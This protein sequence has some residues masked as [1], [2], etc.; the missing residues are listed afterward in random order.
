M[1]GGSMKDFRDYLKTLK[2]KN[3]VVEIEDA[4]DP[5]IEIGK[6]QKSYDGKKTIFFKQIKG[7]DIPIVSNIFNKRENI[8][9]AI[10]VELADLKDKIIGAVENPINTV[11]I[12]DAPI[13]EVVIKDDINPLKLLPI[14]KHYQKDN[15]RYITSGVILA[16]DPATGV[17][18]LSFARMKVNAGNRINIMINKERH[19]MRYLLKAEKMSRPLEI[20]IIIGAHPA[21]WLEGAMPDGLVMDDMDEVNI[22]SALVGEPFELVKGKTIDLEYPANSEI[23]IEG[24]IIN[25]LRED[26][27]PFGDYS[28]VYDTPPRKNPVIE[29]SAIVMRN[30]PIYHDLLPHTIEHFYLGGIPRETDLLKRAK[31]AV[32]SIKDIHLTLGGCSRFHAVVQIKKQAESEPNHAVI[33]TLFPTESARDIKVVVVVDDDIDVYNSFDVEWAIATRVQWHKDIFIVKN[34]EG[35]L[36]PSAIF[37]TSSSILERNEI[38]T[39]KVGIDATIPLGQPEMR[40]LYERIGF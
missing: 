26:E 25:D 13:H 23:V 2:D 5:I 32:P 34:M 31:V 11:V 24:K 21:L 27:G 10:G 40:E 18:N 9:E 37:N 33:A 35:L 17:R 29:I 36:D 14:P 19:L 6:I 22:A 3:D 28:G 4:V 15:D 1:G 20:A 38:L 7:Y 12:R 30:N 39:S 16:K 8:A